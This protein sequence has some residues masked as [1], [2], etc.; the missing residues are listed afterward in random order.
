MDEQGQWQAV[1]GR[2]ARFDGAF[3]YAVRSTGIYCRPSCP[4]RR[5]R[6]E[7]VVFFNLPRAAEGAGFRSCRRCRPG[8]AASRDPR[9]AWIERVCRYIDQ[10]LQAALPLSRLAEQAELSP[11]HFQRTFKQLMGISPRQYAEARRLASFKAQVRKG[12]TVTSAIYGAGY[13]SGS[14]L[15]ERAS[16]QL[17]MTPAAYRKGGRGM[18][19]RY[20]VAPSPLGRLLVAATERGIAAVSLGDSDAALEATLR[21]EYPA[22]EIERDDTA[23]AP[24]VRDVVRRLAGGGGPTLPLDINATAFQWRVWQELL[25]IP[26]G[27]TRTYG[28][29]ARDLGQPKAA[30]AVAR[31]CATNPVA[32][33]IPCHRVVAGDGGLGGYRWG[34][35]RKKLLLEGEAGETAT[36]KAAPPRRG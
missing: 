29:V 17:G 31:A 20:T 22:A 30:R 2:D 35:E 34:A 16:G 7:H 24:R 23:L 10:H 19:L 26:A 18:R 13:G 27:S 8:L 32:L 4:S 6:R 25:R 33:V 12:E 14:R 36:S 1:L 3:V 5:P 15:Y 9:A 28:E 11:H 21:A